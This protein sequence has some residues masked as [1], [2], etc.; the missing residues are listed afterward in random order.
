MQFKQHEMKTTVCFLLDP[1]FVGW[2][3]VLLPMA[4][5]DYRV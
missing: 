3:L 5:G 2:L 1:L 4:N